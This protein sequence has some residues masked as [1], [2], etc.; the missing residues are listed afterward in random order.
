MLTEIEKNC[1]SDLL[2]TLELDD[3]IEL[4]RTC[5][6]GVIQTSNINDSINAILLH[7]EDI[8]SLLMRKK[9]TRS[10]LFK[11]LHSRNI[12][13]PG[14]S[15][16]S[17]LVDSVIHFWNKACTVVDYQNEKKETSQ[18][19]QDQS[20]GRMAVTF[21]E[22]VYNRINAIVLQDM[23]KQSNINNL[24]ILKEEDFWCDAKLYIKLMQG[25]NIIADYSSEGSKECF[26]L[27]KQ[28]CKEHSLCF[29]PNLCE[30]GTRGISEPHGVVLVMSCGTLH[31]ANG[32]HCVGLYEQIFGLIKD[33]MSDSNW[34]IK[35]SKL[36]LRSQE[37]KCVP[38][39][40]Q[41]NQLF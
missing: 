11:Y 16:K 3:L 14:N 41:E 15:E 13:F 21:A 9:I 27:I 20:L 26:S 8:R 17:M 39:L 2:K 10:V 36:A 34:K 25:S 18:I 24:E 32:H 12:S 22:W 31:S 40:P 4:A 35:G 1:V 23:N 19:A 6:T 7:S 30:E 28:I 37:V 33:P 5:T 38:A 29:S